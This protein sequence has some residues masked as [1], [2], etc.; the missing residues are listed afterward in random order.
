MTWWGR[1]GGVAAV[2]LL[3][4]TAWLARADDLPT[5]GAS[6]ADD[7]R[8]L[9]VVDLRGRLLG[10]ADPGVRALAAAE[11]L[12]RSDPEALTVVQEAFKSGLEA[13]QLALLAAV[14]AGHDGRFAADVAALVLHPKETLAKAATAAAGDLPGREM[15]A[16]LIDAYEHVQNGSEARRRLLAGLAQTRS[17][18]AVPFLI[19]L[20]DSAPADVASEAH[21][22]LHGITRA[23]FKTRPEWD[24]WWRRNADR[25]RERWL[26]DALAA[27]D[28]AVRTVDTDTET[29]LATQRALKAEVVTLRLDAARKSGKPEA[30]VALLVD[31]LGDAKFAEI[32]PR[33]LEEVARIPRARAGPLQAPVA[34]LLEDPERKVVLAAVHAMGKIGDAAAAAALARFLAPQVDADLRAAAV[35]GLAGVG[36]PDVPERLVGALNDPDSR[37]LQAVLEGIKTLHVRA[38]VPRLR[39]ILATHRAEPELVQAT[40]EALG[41]SGDAAAV[42]AITE[43]L[44]GSE[45]E[46]DQKAR[47][48]AANALGKLKQPDAVE[49]LLPLL[50]DPYNDLRQAAVEALGRLAQPRAADGLSRVVQQDKDPVVRELAAQALGL[51]GNPAAFDVLITALGDAEPRVGRAAWTSIL[52]LGGKDVPT[53]EALADRLFAANRGKEAIA[54]LRL[55][56][57]APDLAPE[58]LTPAQSN[59]QLR[60]GNALF[61]A[62]E[63]KEA[64][65]VLETSLKWWPDNRAV[66][67]KLGVV[68]REQQNAEGAFQIFSSLL[69]GLEPNSPEW[70]QLKIDRLAVRLLR[71]EFDYVLAEAQRLADPSAAP[72]APELRTRLDELR[73]AAQQGAADERKRQDARRAQVQAALGRARGAGPDVLDAVTTE[74]AALGRETVPDLLA[75]LQE[76]EAAD[77]AAAAACLA[78]ITSIT[79]PLTPQSTPE[80][81]AQ[82]I[83]AWQKWFGGGK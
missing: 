43:F 35:R 34:S 50:S 17:R 25:G 72:T 58:A 31:L 41:E 8:A 75:I 77:W 27:S 24:E 57:P 80:Q 6:A 29:L 7:P 9:G 5:S 28:A 4:T 36:T 3:V 38:S 68:Y 53:L 69:E 49:A 10:D 83:D 42:P 18:H 45:P 81:R 39:E 33:V 19:G 71:R 16:A 70:W 62:R 13:A 2:A 78:R 30:E 12:R 65:P 76:G 44:T 82:A 26:E 52:A 20:L 11:L 40:L 1:L 79:A 37:V 21:R 56:A 73:A 22:A 66:K 63:W 51:V 54:I 14:S 74:I 46:K 15:A 60:L 23:R 32:R 48:A 67:R 59:A 55:L 64:Q 61:E 47:W